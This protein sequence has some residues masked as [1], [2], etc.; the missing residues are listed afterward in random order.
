[1]RGVDQRHETLFSYVRPVSRVPPNHPLRAIRRITDRALT[2]LS[3]RFR[4]AIF[5]S[6]PALDS[7]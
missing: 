5:G 7:A 2:A 3:D 4:R 1:M 6:R